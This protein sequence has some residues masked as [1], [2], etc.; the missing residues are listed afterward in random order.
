MV[1]LNAKSFLVS[2]FTAFFYLYYVLRERRC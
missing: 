2:S 1:Q